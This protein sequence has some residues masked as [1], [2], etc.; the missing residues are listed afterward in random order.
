[1]LGASKDIYLALLAGAPTPLL[2]LLPGIL[3]QLCFYLFLW[4]GFQIMPRAKEYNLECRWHRKFHLFIYLFCSVLCC[5]GSDLIGFLSFSVY[6]GRRWGWRQGKTSGPPFCHLWNKAGCSFCDSW[7]WRSPEARVPVNDR[8][9][10]WKSAREI[11]PG[12][13]RHGNCLMLMGLPERAFVGFFWPG[14]S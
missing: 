8:F 14:A 3:E 12:I 5:L 1:M 13:R 2:C 11:I 7:L 6:S 4:S 10:I 9:S